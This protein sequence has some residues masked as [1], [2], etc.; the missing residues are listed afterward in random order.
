MVLCRIHDFFRLPVQAGEAG[1]V[2]LL[3]LY[4]LQEAVHTM[5][6]PLP[7]TCGGSTSA[8][9][10]NLMDFMRWDLVFHPFGRQYN[11]LIESVSG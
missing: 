9:A 11:D 5:V 8:H 7:P 1:W 4:Q 3:V 2:V 6:H 10:C